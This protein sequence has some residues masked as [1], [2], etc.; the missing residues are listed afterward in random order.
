MAQLHELVRETIANH[1]KWHP[2]KIAQAV[3]ELTEPEQVYDFYLALLEPY[4]VQRIGMHRNNTLNNSNAARSTKLA[5]RRNWWKKLQQELVVV[6]DDWKP[7]GNCSID[8]LT[9]V[10]ALRE[11]KIGEIRGQIEKYETIIAAMRE[12]GAAQVSDL[13]HDAVQ[14]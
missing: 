14:L 2:H 13:P 12:H 8:D 3:Y 4:V 7:L 6:G 5:R 1:P 10:I 9:A 11:Q